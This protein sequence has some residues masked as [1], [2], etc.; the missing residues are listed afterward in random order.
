MA[1]K[2]E[3][4]IGNN[5]LSGISKSNWLI[6]QEKLEYIYLYFNEL[7]YS[8]NGMELNEAHN[9]KLTNTISLMGLRKRHYVCNTKRHQKGDILAFTFR[10]HLMG[11]SNYAIK[12]TSKEEADFLSKILTERKIRF[13]RH[14]E[15]PNMIPRHILFDI[16][17]KIT[18]RLVFTPDPQTGL[19]ILNITNYDG[20]WNQTLK[21][22][23]ERIN[24]ELLDEIGRFS[25]HQD[26]E[27]L[28]ITGNRLS[29]SMLEKLRAKLHGEEQ[30]HPPQQQD[31][32]LLSLLKRHLR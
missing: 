18:T 13:Q 19:I 24:S 10:Y 27:L 12:V 11:V 9:F 1:I 22:K 7:T 26:N 20:K 14:D 6:N 29:L 28:E 3:S 5:K 17:P 21:F 31:P 4:R 16:T 23:P 8:I 30:K 32:R 15:N 2:E 25:L